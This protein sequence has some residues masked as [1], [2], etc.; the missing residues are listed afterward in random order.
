MFYP[1]ASD[2][3]SIRHELLDDSNKFMIQKS[4]NDMGINLHSR[5]EEQKYETKDT[6]ND[7]DGYTTL[8]LKPSILFNI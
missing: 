3:Q 1:P 2:S 6:T 5:V 8:M 4:A 7:K